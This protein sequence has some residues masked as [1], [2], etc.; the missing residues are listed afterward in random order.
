MGLEPHDRAFLVCEPAAGDVNQEG[1]RRVGGHRFFAASI[2]TSPSARNGTGTSLG[3]ADR[4]PA[5]GQP[6]LSSAHGGA[7][8][9]TNGG[10]GNGYTDNGGRG[11]GWFATFFIRARRLRDRGFSHLQYGFPIYR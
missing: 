5:F 3:D 1:R 10:F 8:V 6:L 2:V 11:A 4:C 9:P 7:E